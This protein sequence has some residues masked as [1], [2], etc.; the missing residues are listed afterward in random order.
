MMA[1]IAELGAPRR[2]ANCIF[3][4]LFVF[5]IHDLHSKG[6]QAMYSLRIRGTAL[7]F[8][9]YERACRRN[10]LHDQFRQHNFFGRLAP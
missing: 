5:R 10:R 1:H 9:G 4:E 8:A 3:N 2:E 7:K 6:I